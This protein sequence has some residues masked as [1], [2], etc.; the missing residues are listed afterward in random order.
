MQNADTQAGLNSRGPAYEIRPFFMRCA[1]NA[2]GAHYNYHTN[3]NLQK[4]KPQPANYDTTNTT[5]LEAVIRT[6]ASSECP[7][8]PAHP[9]NLNRVF[10]TCLQDIR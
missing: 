5:M 4:M 7:D 9:R 2:K 3:S 6:P 1:L 8:E 10:A